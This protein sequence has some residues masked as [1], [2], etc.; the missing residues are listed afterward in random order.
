MADIKLDFF[1]LSYSVV[2]TFI[3]FEETIAQGR[4]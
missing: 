4:F 3:M 1:K 2:V